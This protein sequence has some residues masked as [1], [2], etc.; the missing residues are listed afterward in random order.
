MASRKAWAAL[1]QEIMINPTDRMLVTVLH[2][3]ARGGGVQIL[4]RLCIALR[5][6][7]ILFVSAIP[8][9]SGMASGDQPPNADVRVCDRTG[10]VRNAIV[11]ATA[12]QTCDAVTL[13]HMRDITSLDL[14]N[15]EITSLSVGDFS[16]L[17]SLR[18][19]DLSGNTLESLPRGLF[20]DL[21]LLERLRL[22][23]NLLRTL[24]SDNFDKLLLLEELA[25][26]NNRFTS[27]PNGLFDDLSRFD[28]MQMNGD[29]PEDSEP[30]AQLRS[31]LDRHGITS[32]EEFIEALPDLHKE[33][34]V[35]VYESEALGQTSSPEPIQELFPGRPTPSSSSHG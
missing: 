3:I 30:L 7:A 18:S 33:R 17:R 5:V 25:L 21:Y 31:F 13:D 29:A 27:L 8:L 6:T 12:A 24:P 11:A 19:L 16:G 14:S 32:V 26:H 20:N 15:Q 2:T 1:E 22:N 35:F 4:R 28:G 10:K 9:L 23:D 34:F